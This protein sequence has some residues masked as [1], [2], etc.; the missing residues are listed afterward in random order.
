[1]NKLTDPVAAIDRR[2]WTDASADDSGALRA[3]ESGTVLFFPALAFEVHPSESALFAPS[4]AT[5]KNISF[6]P[7]TGRTGGTSLDGSD[8]EALTAMMSRFS[9]RADALVRALL[10]AY[11]REIERARTSFRPVEIAG[12]ATSWRQDDT[13]LHIDSFPATP[14]HG[15]RILRVFTNVN[16]SGHPRTW[17]VGDDFERVAERF[18]SR[19]RWPWPGSAALSR[20]LHLTKTAR[21]TYDALML[22]LHDLMKSDDRFQQ[23]SPQT[24]IHF[25]P[26]STWL[27]FTDQVSHAAMAGQYQFEQTFLLPVTAMAA[28]ERSPLRILE[29]L[30]GRRL[31]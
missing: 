10:P 28:P 23:E 18:H 14:V 15:R 9:D 4:M 24:L 7:R 20:L 1:M 26:G 16:P 21:S 11:A 30:T 17:R 6:D 31:A 19:F 3:L 8:A 29:R 5:S 27:A 2:N 25:A 22:Q 12:R 13:R